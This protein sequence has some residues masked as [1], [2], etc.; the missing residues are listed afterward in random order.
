MAKCHL[1]VHTLISWSRSENF[2]CLETIS[3]LINNELSW[4]CEDDTLEPAA[5]LHWLWSFTTHPHWQWRSFN[6]FLVF[7]VLNINYLTCSLLDTLLF[8]I[9]KSIC[10]YSYACVYRNIMYIKN[11]QYFYQHTPIR[12]NYF[13]YFC[14]LLSLQN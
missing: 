3:R 4:I 7:F 8:L 2:I 9:F 14:I 13:L 10:V 6:L 1:H 11:Y 12:D 5:A